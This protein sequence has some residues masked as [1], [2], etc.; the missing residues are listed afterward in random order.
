MIEPDAVA[1]RLLDEAAEVAAGLAPE[2]L[3]APPRSIA[4]VGDPDGSLAVG[5]AARF[6]GARLRGFADPLDGERAARAAARD[7]RVDV[8]WCGLDRALL[9]DAELV[10]ARLPKSHEE[11]RLLASLAAAHARPEA[12]LLAAARERHLHRAQSEVLAESFGAV[13]ASLGRRKARALVASVPRRRG[14]GSEPEPMRAAVLDESE[15]RAVAGPDPIEVRSLGGAFAGPRLDLGTRALLGALAANASAPEL[16]LAPG[17]RVLDLGCGTGL[18]AIAAARRWPQAAVVGVDRSW[19]A[20]ESARASV[21]ANGLGER[22]RIIRDVAADSLPAERIDLV[23]C[24]PPFHDDRAVD[25]DL[26]GPIFAG[27]A[28]VLRRGGAMATVFNAHLPHRAALARLV[29]P[30]RQ[31]ARDPRFIVTSSIRP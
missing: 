11:L 1:E 24:N 28:R 7:H 20:V 22:V 4:L 27:A 21:A 9:D 26:A 6:P 19:Q 14:E 25:E 12:V 17:A 31:L 8:T 15:L 30:T 5:A 29:G 3:P 23:L 2:R 13:R 18:L 16:Q 10:L